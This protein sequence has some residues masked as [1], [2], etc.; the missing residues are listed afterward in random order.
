MKRSLICF[1]SIAAATLMNQPAGWKR[2]YSIDL[3]CNDGSH[4]F[5]IACRVCR[6]ES[7]YKYMIECDGQPHIRMTKAGIDFILESNPWREPNAE[8]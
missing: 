3:G 8:D 5:V 4:G 1:A 6:N 2:F 7:S